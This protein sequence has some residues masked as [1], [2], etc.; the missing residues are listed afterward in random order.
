MAWTSRP[1]PQIFVGMREIT[2]I[3][4]THRSRCWLVSPIITAA[5]HPLMHAGSA[6][7]WRVPRLSGLEVRPGAGHSIPRDAI[8]SPWVLD[9]FGNHVDGARP[10]QEDPKRPTEAPRPGAVGKLARL[11]LRR[12]P[13]HC[14]PHHR[15]ALRRGHRVH[16]PPPQDLRGAKAAVTPHGSEPG[17]SNGTCRP[18]DLTSAW[19]GID[20]SQPET[21]RWHQRHDHQAGN[22]V[23]RNPE[24]QFNIT[25]HDY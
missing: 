16:R 1:E 22:R 11:G 6:R 24:I 14:P 5:R 17:N 10:G 19:P 20:T 13:G 7:G 9:G 15:P 25:R 4:P 18:A 23:P 8:L 3:S 2:K 21:A 12:Q